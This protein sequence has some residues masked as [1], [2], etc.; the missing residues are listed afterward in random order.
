MLVSI[1]CVITGVWFNVIYS[2]PST[3][4]QKYDQILLEAVTTSTPPHLRD[5]VPA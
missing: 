2:L 5:H 3:A 4:W 1:L